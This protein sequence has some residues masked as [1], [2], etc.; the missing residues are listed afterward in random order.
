[1][2]KYGIYIAVIIGVAIVAS[3]V[4]ADGPTPSV[5][6]YWLDSKDPTTNPGMNA[7]PNQLLIRT[8]QPSIYYKSGPASTAWTQLGLGG[9][10]GGA[11]TGTGTNPQ[12][13]MWASP[14]SLQNA[15]MWIVGSNVGIN[16]TNPQVPL[17]ITTTGANDAMQTRKYFSGVSAVKWDVTK[18]GGTEA[19]PTTVFPSWDLFSI[20]V[21]GYDGTA[22][23]NAILIHDDVDPN[24]TVSPGHVPGRYQVWTGTNVSDRMVGLQ[25]DSTHTVDMPNTTQLE[26]IGAGGLETAL[27][28][29][30]GT[31][32]VT[33][34][35]ALVS[36][37]A[38][39]S[40]DNGT[41]SSDATNFI[42][43]V[44]AIGTHTSV[45]LTFG[46]GG[47]STTAHCFH[48]IAN[49]NGALGIWITPSKT[50]P[51]FN[52]FDTTTGLAANCSDFE[53]HC[54]GH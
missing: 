27:E 42:G 36:C 17:D 6:L 43:R 46:A 11:V 28:V 13:A 54:W 47:F 7:P 23:Q 18:A 21:F 2:K 14:S 45:T 4:L 39:S 50:A 19:A 8:D 44:T 10:P 40:V 16:E 15:P 33:T 35:A 3:V 25:I 37:V 53:Y 9:G 34:R 22:Y 51:V 20:A 48:E 1:M 41:L 30:S 49:N 52:C 12:V 5:G 26:G 29:C 38:P 32:N 31:T 24:G